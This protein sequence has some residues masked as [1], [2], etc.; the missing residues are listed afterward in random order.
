MIAIRIVWAHTCLPLL[1][2]ISLGMDLKRIVVAEE[3]TQNSGS[4]WKKY[5]DASTAPQK[6]KCTPENGLNCLMIEEP[7]KVKITSK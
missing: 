5:S 1:E 6:A 2:S 3:R 7:S 4:L